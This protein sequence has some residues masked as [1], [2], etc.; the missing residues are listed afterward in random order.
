MTETIRDKLRWEKTVDD[1]FDTNFKE[2][3]RSSV[4]ID[5]DTEIDIEDESRRLTAKSLIKPVMGEVKNQIIG[6]AE[7][8]EPMSKAEMVLLQLKGL[9]RTNG[10]L[11]ALRGAY[12][13][14][15]FIWLF[16]QA[17]LKRCAQMVDFSKKDLE[18]AVLL[19]GPRFSNLLVPLWPIEFE[20]AKSAAGIKSDEVSIS[21][22]VGE[23]RFKGYEIVAVVHSHSGRGVPT[24]STID[25]AQ[26][27]KHEQRDLTIIGLI[28]TSTGHLRFY[29]DQ[30]DFGL[31]FHGNGIRRE[32]SEVY[33]IDY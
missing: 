18:D 12:P 25:M 8:G 6:L 19:T 33:R 3:S 10:A 15:R 21:E 24:P 2:I 23:L 27:R 14:N 20:K 11:K 28:F 1:F 5:S 4:V 31:V 30:L 7:T 9:I 26:Q 13:S 29:S 16:E 22:V 17:V 32:S